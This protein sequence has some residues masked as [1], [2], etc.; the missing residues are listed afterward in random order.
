SAMKPLTFARQQ[1]RPPAFADGPS[2]S[3]SRLEPYSELEGVGICPPA[4]SVP[5]HVLTGGFLSLCSNACLLVGSAASGLIA[6]L[7][8]VSPCKK[9]NMFGTADNYLRT[10]AKGSPPGT[11]RLPY[12]PLTTG[13][14]FSSASDK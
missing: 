8:L 6:S 7:I 10:A 5:P 9:R 12:W 2:H 14:C 3:A 4:V 13:H 11:A 1:K